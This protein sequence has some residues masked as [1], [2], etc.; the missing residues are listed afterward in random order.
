MLNKEGRNQRCEVESVV[1]S[2]GL[3]DGPELRSRRLLAK[4]CEAHLEA[5]PSQGIEG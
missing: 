1:V 4:L 2:C 5:E 3:K